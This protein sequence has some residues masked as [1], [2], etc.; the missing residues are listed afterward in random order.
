MSWQRIN[1]MIFK[2]IGRGGANKWFPRSFMNPRQCLCWNS[3][4]S[5]WRRKFFQKICKWDINMIRATTELANSCIVLSPPVA[6]TLSNHDGRQSS[7]CQPAYSAL[8]T[9][10]VQNNFYIS[11][12]G[13]LLVLAQ[14]HDI[15][16]PSCFWSQNQELLII[17]FQR[18]QL[19][20]PLCSAFILCWCCLD[21][22]TTG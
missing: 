7:V 14:M 5:W 2:R 15:D 13:F 8:L 11:R 4:D 22:K 16:V 21:Y 20:S 1:F 18:R 9:F 10:Q 17:D 12:K 19:W 6:F 3:V